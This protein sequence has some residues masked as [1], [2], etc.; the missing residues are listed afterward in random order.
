MHEVYRGWRKVLDAYGEPDRILCAEAWV[1]PAHRLARYVRPDEMHQAFNFDF[2]DAH[3]D[4]A[5]LRTV[6][7]ASLRS[8]DT[9][10]APT[11]WVLSNHDV[12][13]H[14]SRLGLDQTRPRPNGIRATDPQP[15][16]EVGLRRA[17][18]ATALMLALPGGAYLYQG[19]ELGL[20]EHTTMPDE[21]RQDP[22][23]HRTGGTVAGRDGCR[24]PMPW[25]KDAPS[26][27]FGPGSS[28]WLPQPDAYADLAVDQQVGVEGSTLELYRA[29]LEYRR[30]HRFGHGS[31][32]WDALSSDDV[33]A[34][35]NTSG[36]GSRTL[37]VVTNLGADP[38][39][40]P[41]GDVLVSSGPL[42]DDGLVPTDTTAWLRLPVA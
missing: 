19:E 15:D 27:G 25:A 4:A 36:D 32:R 26:L 31:L 17:R 42:T 6:I 28:P 41:A 21:V 23:F 8:N 11:T 18:A 33:I 3:W 12:V 39:R 20:P 7:E 30:K 24:V 22:T 2:L 10:G 13:R 40:L 9:V 16:A 1:R 29:L 38:V 5:A 37:L 34:L 35:R 14:A